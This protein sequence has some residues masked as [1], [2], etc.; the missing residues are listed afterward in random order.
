[1]SSTDDRIVRMQFD[2]AQFK[3]GAADTSKALADVN[4][5]VA[6]AGKGKGLLDLS[7]NM[8][9]VSASASAMAVVATTALATI[10][11]KATNVGI[12][13][14]K[15]LTVNP[16]TSG[17]TEY[18]SLLTKLNTITNATGKS[19]QEVTKILNELN[20]Y[21]DETIYSFSDM[22]SAIQKFVNAGVP[23][24]R[25]VASVKGIANAA[26]FAGAS[27]EEAGRAMYAFSQSMSVGYIML[28]DWNQIENANMGTVQFKN[29][30]IE[31]AVEAGTLTKRGKEYITASGK[32]VSATK[33][34]RDGLQE[35]WATTEVLN[36]ALGKYSDTTTELGR[37]AQQS[38]T[39][40]RTFTAFMDT[41]KET[42]GSGWAGIFMAM[43]GDLDQATAMWTGLSESIGEYVKGFFLWAQLSLRTWREMGGATKLMEGF[44]N[45]LSPVGALLTTI[46]KAYREAFPSN[47]KGAG[48]QLYG[49]SAGFAAITSPLQLLAD[50][51]RKTGPAMTL[52]FRI[53]RGGWLSVKEG[54]KFIADFVEKL[55][56]MV[57]VKLPSGGGFVSFIKD[58]AAAI[59][60]AAREIDDL[61]KK[62]AS[63]TEA[64]GSVSFDM[65]K[66]PDMPSMPSMSSLG[67]LFGGDTQSGAQITALASGVK[68][69]TGGV[70]GLKQASDEAAG[71][72]MFNPDA[73]LNTDRVK[74]FS[75]GFKK[76]SNEVSASGDEVETV[77]DKMG[78]VLSNLKDSVVSF[79]K[80]F[81]MEDLTSAFNMAVLTTMVVS[82]SRFFN[83]LSKSFR[84]FVGIGES[85]T[86]VLDQAGNAL[87]SF[88]T[89]ARAKLIL[90]IAIAVGIL[91]ASLWLLSKIPADDMKKALMGMAGVVLLLVITMKQMTKLIDAMDQDGAAIKL[92]ALAV[93]VMALGAAMLML[94]LAMKIL[95]YVKWEDVAKGLLTMRILLIS[96]EN[97]AKVSEDNAAKNMISAAAAIALIAGSMVVLAL[98]LL[99]FK[100]IDWEDMG[101]AGATLAAVSLAVGLLAMIPYVGIEK[102]G[103]AM[104]ATSVGMLAL[105]NALII[106]GFVK[107]ESMGK[108]AVMLTLLTA[109]IAALMF[110]GGPV[111]VS[112]LV[113][114]SV[115][116][117]GLAAAALVLNNV[118]W[119]SI[120]K[121]A[122][123]LTVLIVAIAALLAV[124]YLAAPVVPLLIVLG[125][126]LM[127][128]ALAALA[129][130]AALAIALPL[131]AAGTAAFAAMATGAAI[132]ITVFMQTLA[133]EAPLLKEAFLTIL[134]NLIDTIV[135]AVPMIIDGFQRLWAA[136]KAQFEGSGG[137]QKNA[138]MAKSGKSW[139]EKLK[140]GIASKMSLIVEKA[141]ELI[142]KFL[143]GISNRMESIAAAGADLIAKFIRGV[144]SKI[145][146]IVSAAVDLVVKFINAVRTQMPRVANSAVDLII[147]FI[148]TVG[149]TIKNRGPEV[150]AAMK[151]LG[152][153]IVKG[154][155]AGVKA[156]AGSALSAI[157]SLASGMVNKAKSLFKIKSPSR[158]FMS[159]G[160]FLAQG[161]A[162]GIKNNAAAAITSVASMVSGTI[163]TAN[164]YV[165]KFIQKLDQD[166]IAAQAKAHGLAVAADRATKAANKTKGKKDDRKAEALVAGAEK[167]Q[168]A[169]E[170]A[171]RKAESAKASQDKAEEFKNA[172]LFGKAQMKSQD[173]QSALDAAK[174]AELRAAKNLAAS[175]ALSQRAKSKGV[176]AK[177]RKALNAEAKRLREQSKLDAQAANNAI[178]RAR[179]AAADSLAWQKK[180]GEEAAA[181][182]QNAFETEAKTAQEE[183]A[184]ESLSDADKAIVRRSQAE[185]LRKKSEEDLAAAKVL[186]YKDL[187]AANKLAE[188]AL[189]EAEQARKYLEEAEKFEETGAVAKGPAV[190]IEPTEAAA[191]AFNRFADSY[192][193]AQAAA[194]ASASIEFNQYNSSPENLNP[195]EVY[196]RTNNLLTRA[197]DIL[198]P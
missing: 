195:T 7:A 42:I 147:T 41:L 162:E 70:T 9:R 161:L 10:A 198:V 71:S 170:A 110:V 128:L 56:S 140:E 153:N 99:M 49:I 164:E 62:G 139:I 154:L 101:K 13:M 124:L 68:D 6:D 132:A 85:V 40:V 75:D 185:A 113:S 105:A 123:I 20:K 134:Q 146:G 151:D 122:L 17:F 120:G 133:A 3:K 2:N 28:Q 189:D 30:L 81:T 127:L 129:F 165:S 197:A 184:F 43:F 80:G 188:F 61:L 149:E 144:A 15:S 93:A 155:I 152:V 166:T 159:I 126:G 191:I 66:L 142:L 138:L 102:V 135:E 78:G 190:N 34:W 29:T 194:A 4:K 33:G 96:L 76:V 25:S 117:I 169:A 84:G 60:K 121:I 156:Q 39:E 137:N 36:D 59:A 136:V 11:N 94:A 150:I 22:T 171:E 167:A 16:V 86:G 125:Q 118:E 181:A 179:T 52:F 47:G 48:K 63:L 91:A 8:G 160:A 31:A 92:V 111:A 54:G 175:N 103:L 95:Q 145:G 14:A 44:K 112:G 114:L 176:S 77:G 65:P 32:V 158:I 177:E 51:I 131:A 193:Q 141:K 45:I 115:A 73:K 107:W 82:L 88:Q 143:R 178:Q 5:S 108:A 119:A 74:D 172:D 12:D 106:F 180:A 53:L 38:A 173:A 90:N 187:E 168:K 183:K 89:A 186:A 163:A 35:Q 79:I 174:A 130:A 18:E 57:E 69:L 72:G 58:L 87:G 100:L 196:R 24:N 104:L 98:A 192:D 37:K 27:S 19:Q 21:S 182:F 23:L 67:G 116:M 97:I 55:A 26:A 157:G 64:F 148:K 83:T 50:L 1:M 109:S 46:G